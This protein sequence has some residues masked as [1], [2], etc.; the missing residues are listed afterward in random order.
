MSLL[1][2]AVVLTSLEDVRQV[3]HTTTLTALYVQLYTM[4]QGVQEFSIR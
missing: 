2:I 1:E 4:L 3:A